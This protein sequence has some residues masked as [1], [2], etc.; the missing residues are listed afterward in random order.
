MG[1]EGAQKSSQRTVDEVVTRKFKRASCRL[2][3]RCR[4]HKGV[5]LYTS[6]ERYIEGMIRNQS[7]GGFLLETPVYF[8]EGG[9][10][11]V[12]FNSPDGR[13]MFLGVVTIKWVKRVRDHFQIGCSAD[14]LQR[15]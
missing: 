13:Q 4:R 11:E 10:L 2:R 7:K 5:G 3:L 15:L 9:K 12:A 8:P 6:D 14:E 1:E